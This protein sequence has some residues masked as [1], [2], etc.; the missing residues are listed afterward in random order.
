[1]LIW[2]SGIILHPSVAPSVDGLCM[3]SCRVVL[4]RHTQLLASVCSVLLMDRSLC[5]HCWRFSFSPGNQLRPCRPAL[6]RPRGFTRA[7]NNHRSR[8]CHCSFVMTAFPITSLPSPSHTR[9]HT[10]SPPGRLILCPLLPTQSRGFPC[11]HLTF[12]LHRIQKPDSIIWL[13][14]ESMR[15]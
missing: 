2:S 11:P 1:M 12:S 5:G 10:H 6:H 13:S 4:K 3:K 9:T 7:V 15:Q 8:L 14:A